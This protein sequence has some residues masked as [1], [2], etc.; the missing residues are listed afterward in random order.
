MQIVANG[1]GYTNGSYVCPAPTKH[2]AQFAE[3]AATLS[4]QVFLAFELYKSAYWG[5][6]TYEAHDGKDDVAARAYQVLLLATITPDTTTTYEIFED[7]AKKASAARS[8]YSFH[9]DEREE[10]RNE[11]Q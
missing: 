10:V 7:N 1:L 8:T 6:F 4:V 5:S 9:Y 2:W 11:G 3:S